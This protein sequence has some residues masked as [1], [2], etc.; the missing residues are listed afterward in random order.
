MNEEWWEAIIRCDS[1]YDGTFFYGVATTGIFCRPSCKSKPPKKENVRIF[2]SV[3]EAESAQFRP[4]KRCR[5]DQ[6]RWPD[7]E[8]AQLAVALIESRYQEPLTLAELARML[9]VSP[10]HLHRTFARIVG[11]TPAEYLRTTRLEAA[12]R[13][14]MKTD[15]TIT[16]IAMTVGFP[17]ASHFSTVF[18]K[19]VG[20]TPTA[21]RSAVLEKGHI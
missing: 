14:L 8:L 3:D 7:E 18:Q 1:A 17:S 10:Y 13:L 6:T 12:Q 5:P 16:D 2:F 4:C 19:H 21:F 11:Q 20:M 15:M 9:H